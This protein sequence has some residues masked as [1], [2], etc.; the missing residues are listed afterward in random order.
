MTVGRIPSVE[1]GIQPTI[2]DAKAD[3]LTATAAD[4]P[5]RLAVGANDTV[6]TADSSTATG[7]KWAT[8]AGA[9]GPA[10]AVDSAQ[11]D[12]TANTMTKIQFNAEAFDTDNCFNT[13]TYRFTPTKAG[14]YQFNI[15]ANTNSNFFVSLYKNGS[16]YQ[17]LMNNAGGT[18]YNSYYQS[19]ASTLISLNGSTDYVEF[20]IASTTGATVY[21]DSYA[22]FCSG[23]WIRS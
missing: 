6:L 3:I 11:F 23:V 7:L 19:S 12:L 13:T 22:N 8:P 17:R 10:F 21:G 9:S 5:A 4:T 1:G 2:F 20:Y 16:E 14:K 15:T 18:S